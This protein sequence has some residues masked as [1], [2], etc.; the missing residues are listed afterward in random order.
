[1]VINANVSIIHTVGVDHD[2]KERVSDTSVL[3]DAG[4]CL[5]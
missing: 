2:G 1:M 5:T 4:P 3:L